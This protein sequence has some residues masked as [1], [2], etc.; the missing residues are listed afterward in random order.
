LAEGL[1]RGDVVIVAIPGE[2]G[3]PRPAVV[4]QSNLLAAGTE[5]L[6][7]CPITSRTITVQRMRPHL[8]PDE[9]N[10]LRRPSQVMSDKITTVHL[11]KVGQRIGRIADD[12][13]QRIDFSLQLVLGFLD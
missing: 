8:Q 7:I 13:L 6:I 10:G 3:K 2:F 4:V 11:K 9:I 1:K 12:D 5:S